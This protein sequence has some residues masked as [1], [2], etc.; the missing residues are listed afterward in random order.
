MIHVSHLTKA[1]GPRVAIKDLSFDV[2][3]GEIVGFLGPNGA[4]KSTTM[5]ILTGFM[6]AT[7]GT[8]TVAG[9]DVFKQP[10]EVKRRV[11]Y[12]PENPPVYLEMQVDDYLE[13]AA[14]LH[15]M[16]GTSAKKAVNTVIEKTG[17]GEV[18]GR[19][20]GNLS[21]GYRQRVGLAQALVHS[22]EILILDEPTVGLDPAQIIE[23]RG[24][25]KSL[26]GNHTVILSSHI[27]PE[28][29]AT[30]ERIIIISKGKIA[31][32]DTLEHLT[33]KVGKGLIYTLSV[34]KTSKDALDQIKDLPGV[35]S[36]KGSGTSVQ[37][38]LSSAGKES[39]DKI[40]EI[41]VEKGMGVLE[42]SSERISLEEVYLKLTSGD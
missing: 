42:F 12:L 24:L 6:P 38:E 10:I 31:A 34:K 28:V 18:K 5:K 20:I 22:P 11:G 3:K 2:R 41:A 39:R 37:I 36:V 14:N 13:F 15:Q 9:F 16:K 27:L 8:A 23:I 19:L 32:E 21:K 40:I 30:C 25:I 4:G 33:K 7:D 29:T 1:Y 35:E 26:G 17:L